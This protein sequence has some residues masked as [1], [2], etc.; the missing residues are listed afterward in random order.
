MAETK[1]RKR[2]RR[3]SGPSSDRSKQRNTLNHET[4]GS[5]GRKRT[6][7][8]LP[9]SLRRGLDLLNPRNDG[10]DSEL[11][12]L[13]RKVANEHSKKDITKWEPLVKRNREAPTVFSMKTKMWVILRSEQSLQNF[14]Q[15][16]SLKG[17]LH[18]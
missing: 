6:G 10:G 18:Q 4:D 15:G 2:D 1:D 9:N 16:P 11:I 12:I 5:R 7:P 17:K 3:R 13:E 8:R 14:N